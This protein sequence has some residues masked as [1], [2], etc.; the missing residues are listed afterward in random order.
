[1]LFRIPKSEV[2]LPAHRAGS[3]TRKREERGGVYLPPPLP[4]TAERSVL[5]QEV[6]DALIIKHR[7]FAV[8]IMP[9]VGYN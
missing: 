4:M 8:H 3:F 5:V 6:Q 1:M 9:R 7:V 2:K